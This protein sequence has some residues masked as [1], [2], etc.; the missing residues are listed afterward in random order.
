MSEARDTAGVI[1]PPPLLALAVVVLG[2]ALDWLLPAYVLTVLLSLAERIVV[3]VVFIAAGLGLAISALGAFKSAGTDAE[4]WKP[5]V[6]LVTEGIFK[7]LRNPMYVG[8]TFVLAGLSVLLASDWMLVMTIIFVPVIHFGVVR[9]EER[10]LSAKFG[11]PY[12]QYMNTV[13]RY[14]WPF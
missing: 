9:R 14:G 12:L 6:A 10:Y 7:W 11:T 1:A 4:P 3:G 5:S 2:L 13:P 8:G